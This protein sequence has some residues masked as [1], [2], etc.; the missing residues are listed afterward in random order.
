MAG[1]ADRLSTQREKAE[2]SKYALAERSGVSAQALSLL[3]LGQREP[4]WKTVQLLAL[5]LGCPVTA[6]LDP[7]LAL[8]PAK[9]KRP[10]GRPRA[11][12]AVPP[13]KAKAAGPKKRRKK[14]E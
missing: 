5:A 13:A 11:T 9:P 3:E 6:F 4:S 10:A 8:P 1:F 14:G 12:P 7:D 2:L